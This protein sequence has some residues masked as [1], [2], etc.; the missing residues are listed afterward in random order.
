MAIVTTEFLAS[1]LHHSGRYVNCD[2]LVAGVQWTT[3]RNGL[4]LSTLVVTGHETRPFLTA[5]KTRTRKK[6]REQDPNKRPEE[7]EGDNASA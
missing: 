3:G 1:H 4:G 5:N 6:P 7:G 2:G